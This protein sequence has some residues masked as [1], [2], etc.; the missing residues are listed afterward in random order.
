MRHF[1]VTVAVDGIEVLTIET[2]MLA[3]VP[4]IDDYADEV[5]ACGEHLLAFIGPADPDPAYSFD[6][7]EP[8]IRPVGSPHTAQEGR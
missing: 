1:R 5:R 4:N 3:G 2:D 7:D 8:S 6:P